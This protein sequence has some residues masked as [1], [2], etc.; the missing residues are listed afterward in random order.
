MVSPLQ[1]LGFCTH[2]SRVHSISQISSVRTNHPRHNRLLIT[3]QG[4]GNASP[5]HVLDTYHET[6]RNPRVRQPFESKRDE[7]RNDTNPTDTPRETFTAFY[8]HAG[9][10]PIVTAYTGGGNPFR[11][12]IDTVL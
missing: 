8:G 3:D 7:A 9:T 4:S 5:V 6:A 10:L 11:A 1:I 2:S 12:C